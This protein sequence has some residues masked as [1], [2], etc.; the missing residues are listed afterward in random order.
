MP[1]PGL[2]SG[3]ANVWPPKVSPWHN[4][5]CFFGTLA[6]CEGI[7]RARPSFFGRSRCVMSILLANRSCQI[8]LTA[9]S[10]AQQ[11][12]VRC[13]PYSLCPPPDCSLPTLAHMGISPPSYTSQAVGGRLLWF[14]FCLVEMACIGGLIGG[15]GGG[16]APD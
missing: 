12:E 4:W 7:K 15:W 3:S 11:N 10:A 1:T 8:V 6:Q 16:A 5:R 13:S 2:T 9:W 14:C